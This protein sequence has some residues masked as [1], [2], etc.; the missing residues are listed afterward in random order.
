[1]KLIFFLLAF[2]LFSGCTKEKKSD[3][4][5]HLGMS[6]D[7]S[8][9]DPA[10]N[11][12]Q[13]SHDVLAQ[14]YE[15]P[16]QYHY[17][18]TKFE[19]VPNLAD[20]LPVISADGLT[21]T[22]KIKPNVLYHSSHVA[23]KGKNRTVTSKDFELAIKRIA[24]IPA[25]SPGLFVIDGR[26]QGLESWQKSV[27]SDWNKLLATPLAGV[28]TPDDLTFVLHLTKPYPA[29]MHV[30]SLLFFAPVPA[31]AFSPE[32]LYMANKDDIGTGPYELSIN[33][34]GLE[35]I[36][37]KFPKY[38]D[39]YFPPQAEADGEF[40]GGTFA[41]SEGKKIPLNEGIHYHI[42][43]QDQTNWFQFLKGNT[44]GSGIPKDF[45]SAVLDSNNNL[46]P[47]YQKQNFQ[48]KLITTLSQWWVGINM[49]HPI[50]GG[51]SHLRRALAYALDR[52]DFIGKFSHGM[53]LPAKGIMPVSILTS[54]GADMPQ[55]TFDLA[56]AKEYLVKAGYPEGRGLPH[57]HFDIRSLG[58]ESRQQAEWFQMQW[59]KIGININIIANSFGAYIEKAKKEQLEIF[60]D[61]WALDY[62]SA[63][64]VTQLLYS[65]NFPP[66]ANVSYY[67]NPEVDKWHEALIVEQDPIK[68]HELIQKITAQV[69]EDLPWIPLFTSRGFLML[70]PRIKNYRPG[71]MFV[72]RL[73]YW[74]VQ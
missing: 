23:L 7:P 51:N 44:L 71:S 21:V 74:E 68:G 1:M 24:F 19:I 60:L 50:L 37:K 15:A 4:Y 66:G 13:V 59:K 35:I 73:K 29:I 61:G 12:D 46:K 54:Q 62:P 45:T 40:V 38:R 34:P 52:N 69:Y 43:K 30:L 31:E 36:L 2:F 5:L 26:L 72:N 49:K 70:S 53:Y 48:L 65:K 28:T 10:L 56:K 39:V 64:N 16:Y 42:Y 3:Q 41:K 6:D 27:G 67:S 11:G 20:G 55:I 17:L 25:A 18:K 14:M 58:A 9:W 8:K 32:E 47:E 33:N 63:D 57:F 22:I